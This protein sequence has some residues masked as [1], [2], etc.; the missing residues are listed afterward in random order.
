MICWLLAAGCWLLAA[1]CWLLAAGCW[2]LAAVNSFFFK[3]TH[4]YLLSPALFYKII[5]G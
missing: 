2:L 1:G 5:T 3:I 4:N